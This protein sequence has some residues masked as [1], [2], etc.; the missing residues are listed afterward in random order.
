M[1][2]ILIAI[3]TAKY[4]ECDTFKSIFDAVKQLPDGYEA[5]FQCFFGYQV[6]QVRNLIASWACNYDY[7]FSVDHDVTFAPDTLAKMIGY[8]VS[9]VSGIYRQRVE[10][11][12]LEIYDLD[13]RRMSIEELVPR[14]L[15]RIGASGMGCVLI[16]SE[17]IRDIGYPQFEYKSA[18]NHN[19]T[20]SE[21][22]DFCV[23]AT[24]KGFSLFCDSTTICGH[25]GST[26]FNVHMPNAVKPFNSVEERFK[27]LRSQKL[28]PRTHVD[29]LMRLKDK[30][31]N[32]KTIYDLGSCVLHWYDVAKEIWPDANIIPI[33][34][35]KEVEPLY[36]SAGIKDYSVGKVIAYGTKDY[37]FYQNLE[38]P[39]GNSLYVENPE[40][41]PRAVELFPESS[42][43]T[44]QA[45]GLDDLVKEKAW[46]WPEFIK[47]DIQ[48]SEME[49]ILTA[50]ECL[51]HAKYV[52]LELQHVD[53]NMGAVKAPTV[54]DYMSKK[55]FDLI[56]TFGGTPLS[57][58]K[59]YLFEKRLKG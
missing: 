48:G 4:V 8:D 2:R 58:D 50:D 41:S 39:G 29:G 35:M 10:E 31:F 36:Q 53:Y 1:K 34:A 46:E 24:R 17:V 25:I 51:N 27:E 59:D 13:L 23:K 28:M 43:V 42:K 56:D 32:P 45:V 5:D 30:G 54:I 15:T 7:L 3:P 40:F 20:F 44:L 14:T 49:A 52:L 18:L 38:H 16:K 37:E 21:D 11:Q 57:V 26:Y 12:H 9:Y 19:A 47:M 22:L 55:G 6:D 33:E